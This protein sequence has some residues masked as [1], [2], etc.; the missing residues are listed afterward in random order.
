MV[1]LRA[2]LDVFENEPEIHP[3]LRENNNVVSLLFT[4][5]PVSIAEAQYL[6]P[7]VAAVTEDI[8]VKGANESVRN[9]IH[10]LRT[11]KP[12]TPVNHPKHKSS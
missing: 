8:V 6:T 11:G 10:Y 4:S 3:K 9:V 1:V 5:V 7:H 2:A 12:T